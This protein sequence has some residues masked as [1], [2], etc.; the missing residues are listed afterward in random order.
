MLSR[1]ELVD[2][3]ARGWEVGWRGASAA[4]DDMAAEKASMQ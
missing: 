3:A 2:K 1:L 4:F